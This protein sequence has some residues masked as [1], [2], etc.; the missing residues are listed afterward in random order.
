VA[1]ELACA[2]CR[3]PFRTVDVDVE[4]GEAAEEANEEKGL[5]AMLYLGMFE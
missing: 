1:R 5:M 3:S 2:T 4:G